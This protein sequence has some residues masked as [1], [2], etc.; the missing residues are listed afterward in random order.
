MNVRS[1]KV[2][3]RLRL[4]KISDI[5]REVEIWVETKRLIHWISTQIEIF[6]WAG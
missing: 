5:P 6:I 4:T 3:N 1:Q 2:R